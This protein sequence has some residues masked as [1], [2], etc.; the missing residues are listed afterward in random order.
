MG[1]ICSYSGE[2]KK[3]VKSTPLYKPTCYTLELVPP[4]D[5]N[6]ASNGIFTGRSAEA[7]LDL[8]L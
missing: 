5:P 8:T 6:P 1:R 2:R 4:V 3:V 7:G